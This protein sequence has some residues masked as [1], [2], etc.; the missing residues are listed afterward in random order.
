MFTFALFAVLAF[1]AVVVWQTRDRNA[2]L[3]GD[4][5]SSLRYQVAR[6]GLSRILIH[7][8]LGMAWTRC[9]CTG[10]VGLSRQRH[11]SPALD[12]VTTRVRSRITDAR[13]LAV[14]DDLVLVDYR[15]RG[16]TC[17]GSGDTNYY[18]ILLGILGALTGFLMSSMVNYNYGDAEGGDDVLVS[19]GND[20]I[21]RLRRLIFC[22]ICGI[23]W[24]TAAPHLARRFILHREH[25]RTSSPP[26]TRGSITTA[27]NHT[28]N[29]VS[30]VNHDMQRWVRTLQVAIKP[31]HARD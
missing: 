16:K 21:H 8:C 24:I 7:P 4:P 10:T 6:V 22:V 13:A 9:S 2:L 20:F 15:S 30:T 11:A 25:T 14:D 23:C 31:T 29:V 18:G 3:L 12:S 19:D 28:F 17:S 27:G 1:A 26:C 5:S